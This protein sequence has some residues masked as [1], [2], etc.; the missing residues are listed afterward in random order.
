MFDASESIEVGRNCLIGPFCYITDHDHGIELARLHRRTASCWQPGPDREQ[1]LDRCRRNYFEGR[2]YRGWCSNWR[3]CGSD[4]SRSLWRK[5]GGC[6]CAD[7]RITLHGE[8]SRTCTRTCAKRH[9]TFVRA[10][11][12]PNAKGRGESEPRVA[13]SFRE[14]I[15]RTS[16]DRLETG[17]NLKSGS[18]LRIG[19]GRRKSCELGAYGSAATQRSM[20]VKFLRT[21]VLLWSVGKCS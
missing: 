4:T 7:D 14:R 10:R 19:A 2:H 17:L 5:G 3:R 12:T 21:N 20:H 9:L 16:G 15:G 11:G 1:C 18:A 13:W 8:Q 6:A